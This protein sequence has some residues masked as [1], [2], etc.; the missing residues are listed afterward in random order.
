MGVA[1]DCE[2][3]VKEAAEKLGGLDVL[4]SNAVRA[5]Q[6]NVQLFLLNLDRDG[7]DSLL[8]MTSKR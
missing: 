7:R 8:W 5:L 1:K 2:R 6:S 3:V 4:I